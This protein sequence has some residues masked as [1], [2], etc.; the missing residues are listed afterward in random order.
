[1]G[2]SREARQRGAKKVFPVAVVSLTTDPDILEAKRRRLDELELR[3]ARLGYSTP[4]EVATEIADLKREIAEAIAPA[5]DAERYLD[6]R[7]VVTRH[8]HILSAI[9]AGQIITLLLVLLLLSRAVSGVAVQ[10]YV[11]PAPTA[12]I[13]RP[14]TTPIAGAGAPSIG[15]R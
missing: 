14:A 5:S 1:V 10:P 9:A 8:G 4:P 13:A 7:A 11:A 6:L 3:A 15:G 2:Q 12:G